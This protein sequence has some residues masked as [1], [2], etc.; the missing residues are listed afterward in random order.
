MAA[1]F[2]RR[3][4]EQKLLLPLGEDTILTHAVRNTVS[5]PWNDCIAVI[6][7]EE[8]LTE[9]CIQHNI[10]FVYNSERHTGQASSIRAGLQ[11]LSADLDG[12]VF[13]PG[14]QPLI[15]ENLFRAL[16]TEFCLHNNDAIIVP[17]HQGMRYSPVLFGSAWRT[18][19]LTLEGDV[20]GRTIIRRNEKKAVFIEWKDKASF[21][22]ADTIEDYQLLKN[23]WR[24]KYQ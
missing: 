11:N 4:G 18:E 14:D 22:D 24:N 12:I 2:S 20:G 6:G 1:G 19:L 15:S 17:T 23:T 16:L 9:I 13:I 5:C 7:P 3:L 10:R 21:L 8:E